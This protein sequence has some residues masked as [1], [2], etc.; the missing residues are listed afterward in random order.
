VSVRQKIGARKIYLAASDERDSVT[1]TGTTFDVARRDR[2]AAA[3]T[4]A[5][6]AAGGVNV[7]RFHLHISPRDLFSFLVFLTQNFLAPEKTSEIL[8]AR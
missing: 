7:G 2:L 4:H 3:G 5:G 8:H 6:S 1:D